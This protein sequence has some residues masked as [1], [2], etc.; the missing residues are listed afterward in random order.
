MTLEELEI[1]RLKFLEEHPELHAFQL[2]LQRSMEKIE[3]P[4]VRCQMITSVMLSHSEVLKSKFNDL[5]ET[6]NKSN[7]QELIQ[8]LKQGLERQIKELE[9]DN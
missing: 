9:S 8:E 2:S 7:L 4:I 5:A 6:V 3:D 1:R